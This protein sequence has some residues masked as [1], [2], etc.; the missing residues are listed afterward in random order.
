MASFLQFSEQAVELEFLLKVPQGLFN[1]PGLDR[2]FHE[3]PLPPP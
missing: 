1:V 3:R 2:Y